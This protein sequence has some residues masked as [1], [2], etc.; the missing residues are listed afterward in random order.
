[1]RYTAI[2]NEKKYEIQ[3]GPNN[4]VIVNGEPH[5][6]DFRTIEGNSLYSL[7]ID[8]LSWEALV[9]R[10]GD[11]YRVSIDGD[12]HVV[13]VED[14]RT[15]KMAKADAGPPA[16]QGEVSVKAPMPGLVRSITVNVGDQVKA[17]QGV[18]ILEAMK[19]EN[20]LRSPRQGIVKEIRVKPGDKV[21][22]GQALVV[23]K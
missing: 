21:V 4:S 9:E 8:N 1:M 13:N 19:M 10:T 3:I 18:V 20:E 7:L 11:E 23:I 17:K 16:A 15:R 12:L 22:Q 6:V 2:I 14:E 5:I